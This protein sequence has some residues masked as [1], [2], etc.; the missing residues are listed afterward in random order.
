VR[1]WIRFGARQP[2]PAIFVQNADGSESL[3]NFSMDQ[4]DVVI[5]RVVERLV[6]RRG[7]LT[8]CIVNR[9]FTG[10]GERLISH[11]VSPLV[12]RVTK[13]PAAKPG[14]GS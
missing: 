10:G 12:K 8:G 9:D 5:Q 13:R 4:G 2:L 1:T 7:H 14:A 6:L 3:V 11:T